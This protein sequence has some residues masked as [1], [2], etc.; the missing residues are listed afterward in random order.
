MIIKKHNKTHMK[1]LVLILG[2][3][4]L[5]IIGYSQKLVISLDT[6][7]EM[8]WPLNTQ[9]TEA[10]NLNLVKYG[11][12][13]A[14]YTTYTFDL[15]NEKLTLV[16]VDGGTDEF[17]ISKFEE[18]N[19]GYYIEVL[20]GKSYVAKFVITKSDIINSTLFCVFDFKEGDT[21]ANGY[22]S[23]KVDITYNKLSN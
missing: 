20:Y 19:V 14:G 8:N 3:S 1:K 7:M 17:V 12:G 15:K 9:L 13:Y 22:Y 16:G 10:F 5:N 6:V 23:N 11:K 4:V 18:N 2:I 21:R